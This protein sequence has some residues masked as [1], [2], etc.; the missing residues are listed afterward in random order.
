MFSRINS[1]IEITE[2]AELTNTVSSTPE[3]EGEMDG[4][5]T[6]VAN[7]GVEP[8]TYSWNTDPEQTTSVAT[9][10]S[11]GTY[12]VTITDANGCESINTVFVDQT[13]GINEIEGLN[14][15]EMFPNPSNGQVSVNIEFEQASDIKLELFNSLGKRVYIIEE[16]SISNIQDTF[17]W[18]KL[19]K[20]MYWL[21]LSVNDGRT[22]KRLILQ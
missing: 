7:G 20:G 6:V 16:K 19:P 12:W 17:E 13:T 11:T 10:L 9:N 4:T 21:A 15:F 8:Y 3:N 14:K 5:A 22:T 2:P 1:C 18:S